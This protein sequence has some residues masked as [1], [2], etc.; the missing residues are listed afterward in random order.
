MRFIFSFFALCLI[1]SCESPHKDFKKH[2]ED[3]YSQVIQFDDNKNEIK[4]GSFVQFSWIIL[5]DKDTL[6]HERIAQEI[7]KT[8]SNGGLIEALSLM[9]EN[10]KRNFIFPL[11]KVDPEFKSFLNRLVVKNNKTLIHQIGIDKI[12]SAQQ[13]V[14]DKKQFLHWVKKSNDLN[15]SSFENYLIQK[16]LKNDFRSFKKS[17]TGFYFK[18]IPG[19]K[20]GKIK[21]GSPIQLK[22]SGGPLIKNGTYLEDEITQDFNVGQELQVIKAIEEALLYMCYGDS[23]VVVSPSHLAFGEKGSSTGIIPPYSPVVYYLKVDS[24]K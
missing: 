10:E 21:L 15:Y 7:K 18:I 8:N 14:M 19:N 4:D 1:I 13:Y 16:F 2:K 23:A 3:F 9:K 5:C 24:L 20:G 11:Q 12:Y 22:Y 17:N 6:L